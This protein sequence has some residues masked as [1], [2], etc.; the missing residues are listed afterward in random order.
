MDSAPSAVSAALRSP[1]ETA[2][3]AFAASHPTVVPPFSHHLHLQ[4]VTLVKH[5]N[6]EFNHHPQNTD[7]Q[8]HQHDPAPDREI[9]E[10][11]PRIAPCP[12]PQPSAHRQARQL[13]A[14]RILAG[15]HGGRARQ[16]RLLPSRRTGRSV[17]RAGALSL[18]PHSQP[19]CP[20]IPCPFQTGLSA[21]VATSA[22]HRKS[23]R[24]A[25][26]AVSTPLVPVLFMAISVE[27]RLALRPRLPP[28]VHP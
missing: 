8:E 13:P 11:R 23:P 5:E 24:G 3:A 16:R 9:R 21:Q 26:I 14:S 19:A 10:P 18:V 20:G 28:P 2:G 7:G 1:A 22:E 6:A 27:R 17:P 4:R 15:P 25:P 12:H